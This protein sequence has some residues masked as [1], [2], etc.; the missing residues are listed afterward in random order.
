MRRNSSS[1]GFCINFALIPGVQV[2][3]AICFHVLHCNFQCYGLKF[4]FREHI[5]IAR[6]LVAVLWSLKW[7]AFLYWIYCSALVNNW[8]S[9]LN[10]LGGSCSGDMWPWNIRHSVV[11]CWAALYGDKVSGRVCNVSI[12]YFVPHSISWSWTNLHFLCNLPA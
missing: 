7:V 1:N 4:W 3:L 6:I 10:L 2:S 11:V 12:L 5:G 8:F 9:M